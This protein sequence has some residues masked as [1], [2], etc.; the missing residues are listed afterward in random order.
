MSTA[1]SF[2]LE[3]TPP[4]RDPTSLTSWGLAIARAL[5]SRGVSAPALF[6]QA[7][8][9]FGA[10]NDPE[11]RYPVRGETRLWELAVAATAD[12]C[13][14][15][16]VARHTSPTTF[17]ALGLSLTASGSLREAFDRIVRY[18]RLVSNGATIRFEDRGE[19]CRVSVTGEDH[20]APE[21]LDAV[22]AVAVRL[23]RSLTDRRFSPLLVEFRCPSPRDPSPFNRC[24]RAPITFDAPINAL[25]VERRVCDRRIPGA[26]PELARVN[27]LVAAQAIER[28]DRSR[29]VDC[30]RVVLTNRL[31]SGAPSARRRPIAA[32]C[33]GS[34]R[35]ANAPVSRWIRR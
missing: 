21:A 23:C 34:A 7:G 9:D 30:I 27:D 5:E 11:A 25:T 19:T 17:H 33:T 15:V 22:L 10:L 31:P 13:F 16:E 18:Y 32:S 6:A 14:G 1:P 28:W 29:I 12:P 26:N 35:A 2:A 24:F 4:T 3:P 8:L 20:V